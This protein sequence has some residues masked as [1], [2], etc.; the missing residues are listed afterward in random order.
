MRSLRLQSVLLARCGL[1]RIARRIV[2]VS[3]CVFVA[4][5]GLLS[6]RDAHAK[7]L[8]INT[9]PEIYEVADLPPDL[10]A[11]APSGNWKLGYMCSHLGIFWADIWRWDCRLVAFERDTYADLPPELQPELEAM[12][13][14]SEAQRG[15]WNQYG[16]WCFVGLA[17]LGVLVGSSDDEE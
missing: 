9:G 5:S 13:P 11:E 12:Y 8:V 4:G 3:I 14:L 16:V 7:F 6:P 10:Q 15:F 1:E 17:G 2:L